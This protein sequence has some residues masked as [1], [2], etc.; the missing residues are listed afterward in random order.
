M[1]KAE[2]GRSK[3][4]DSTRS[5]QLGAYFE[6]KCQVSRTDFV[7]KTVALSEQDIL[8]QLMSQRDRISAAT[9]LVVRDAHI[10]ED[11]FQNVTL[12]AMD[13]KVT[14]DSGG[15]LMSWALITARREGIDWLRHQKNVPVSLDET[16]L[17]VLEA[18]WANESLGQA[19]S[20]SQA[21]RDCL[22]ELPAK[23]RELLRQRYFDGQRCEEVA[24]AL[25]TKLDA[26]Y[27]RLSR[28]HHALKDCI[29]TK[30]DQPVG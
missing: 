8:K 9:W 15:A 11:I 1:E 25:G 22:D 26:I 13:K 24:A 7:L 27:K 19:G 21:L 2:I 16:I 14:F 30:L 17:E 10:A 6:K 3:V 12:K 28:L 29:E 23:S 20:R 18:E 5:V 4:F